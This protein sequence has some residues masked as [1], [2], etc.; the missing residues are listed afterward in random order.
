MP[1]KK[2]IDVKDIVSYLKEEMKIMDKYFEGKAVETTYMIGKY[3]GLRISEVMV[4]H[5]IV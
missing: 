4:L 2:S 1:N 5:G 3:T